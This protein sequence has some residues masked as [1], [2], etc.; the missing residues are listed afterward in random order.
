MIEGQGIFNLAARSQ[1]AARYQAPQKTNAPAIRLTNAMQADPKMKAFWEQA[2]KK[3]SETVSISSETLKRLDTARKSDN[4]DIAAE[5]YRQAKAKLQ[6]L[7]LQA[8]LAAATGDAKTLRR[9]AAEAA[10]A[11]RD[12]ANSVRGLADGIAATAGAGASPNVPTATTGDAQQNATPADPGAE[13]AAKVHADIKAAG[14]DNAPDPAKNPTAAYTGPVP[15]GADSKT[16]GQ[17]ALRKLGDDARGAIGQARGIIAF[18]ANA[19]R[20]ARKHQADPEEEKYFNELQR[21]V[22]DAEHDLNAALGDASQAIQSGG[23]AAAPDA[24]TGDA[25]TGDAATGGFAAAGGTDT[26]IGESTTLDISIT[27]VAIQTTEVGVSA[28]FLV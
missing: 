16:W 26:L 21:S 13:A 2:A 4:K 20:A 17:E 28:N 10:N 12:I 11:A 3:A 27:T 7:R 22:N 18:L 24:S 9:L 5:K 14:N 23:D 1:A 6:A 15:E 19:A 25:A 8:Q